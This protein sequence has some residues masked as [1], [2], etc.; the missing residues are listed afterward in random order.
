VVTKTN[1]DDLQFIEKLQIDA[2]TYANTAAT[3]NTYTLQ[4]N[5][6]IKIEVTKETL[7]FF[8]FEDAEN[9]KK[10]SIKLLKPEFVPQVEKE[11]KKVIKG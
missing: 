9:E 3:T 6:V 5:G 4:D 2:N 10:R 7:S 1:Q 8:D 11:F